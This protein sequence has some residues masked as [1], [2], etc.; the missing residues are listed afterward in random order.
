MDIDNSTSSNTDNNSY[1]QSKNDDNA[2]LSKSEENENLT[3]DLNDHQTINFKSAI[4]YF[5]KIDISKEKELVK[6]EN[7]LT[8]NKKW[9]QK[10]CSCLSCNKIH[11]LIKSKKNLIACVT[12]IKYDDSNSIH[13]KIL[14]TIYK[15]FTKENDCPKSGKHWEKIGFQSKTPASDLRSMGMVAPLQILYLICKYPKFSENLYELFVNKS[16]EWLF[17]V[18]LINLSNINYNLLKEDKLDKHFSVDNSENEVISVFNENFVGM[19]S[20]LDM[21]IREND[22]EVTPEYIMKSIDKIRNMADN[23]DSFLWNAKKLL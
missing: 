11:P 3:A 9:Y 12:K 2:Q 4:I 5:S 7:K 1:A 10:I 13:L 20:V 23:V 15:F 8:S 19:V 14:S 6:E 18:S 21:D 17:I 16:C 22:G